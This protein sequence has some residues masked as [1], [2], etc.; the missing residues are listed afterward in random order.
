MKLKLLLPFLEE[1]ELQQL[2]EKIAAS[3][4]GEYEGIRAVELLPFLEE[5]DV[6]RLLLS[7]Y[8]HGAK[9]TNFYPFASEKG[10]SAL[11]DEVLKREDYAFDIRTLLP[12]LSEEDIQRMMNEI[13]AKGHSFDHLSEKDLFPFMDDDALDEAFLDR[14]RKGDPS[15]K[16]YAPFVSDEAYHELVEDY[17]SGKLENIDL[18][19]YYPFMDESDIRKVF[20]ATLKRS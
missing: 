12:F 8:E 10:L 11:L 2:A 7:S 20:T 15:A 16:N 5:E 17:V 4:D 19:S 9:L 18:D 6:D 3:P 13:L 1:E 14:V